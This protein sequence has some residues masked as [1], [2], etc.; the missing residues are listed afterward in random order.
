MAATA[1][2]G[3]VGMGKDSAQ[4]NLTR[5]VIKRAGAKH[6][7]SFNKDYPERN[8]YYSEG[9]QKTSYRDEPQIS[10]HIYIQLFAKS[11]IIRSGANMNKSGG[12]EGHADKY[13]DRVPES[14]YPSRQ[15]QGRS[16]IA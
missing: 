11:G 3:E 6:S 14:Q 2:I 16:L 8:Q 12:K 9:N 4:R 1:L 10:A 5:L 13:M 15:C 7:P